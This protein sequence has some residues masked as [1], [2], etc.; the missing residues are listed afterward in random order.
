MQIQDA[1][2]IY[3]AMFPNTTGVFFFDQSSAHQAF[4]PDALVARNMN[5]NPGGKQPALHSTQI[6]HNNPNPEL[7]GQ[8]QTMVYEPDHPDHP[9]QP[10]GMEAV[11]KERGLYDWLDRGRG[12]KPVRVC[13]TC[14]LS[15]AKRDQA[16]K[17]A[18][19]RLEEDPETFSSIG[20]TTFHNPFFTF[21]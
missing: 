13:A 16:L 19:E 9:N 10:K 7:R 21:V 1:L 8:S 3:D 14:K 5:V 11:L 6:P 4:S 17:A 12:N 20:N 15:E 2:K 18:K